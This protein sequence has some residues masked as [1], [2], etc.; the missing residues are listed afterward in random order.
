MKLRHI[1]ALCA[2]IVVASALIAALGTAVSKA[3]EKTRVNDSWLAATTKIALFADPRVKGGPV[4]VEAKQGLVMLRG[5][6]DS[7]VA[8]NA[9][10]DVA[11]GLDGVKGVKND[12]MV[13]APSRRV[14]VRDDDAAITARV[15]HHIIKE[16]RLKSTD[17]DV[18]TNAGVVSLT[19]EV[20]SIVNSA[21]ASWT[22]WQVYGVK[23]VQND[24][25]LKEK[26]YGLLPVS[27]TPS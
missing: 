25:T 5:T 19:G 21:Q 10:E 13:V 6:V 2:N 26:Q 3:S 9:S 16:S 18:K 17:I 24:L 8:K 11:K 20:S 12:L 15:K 27:K 4:Y 22:A 23:A 7:H 1:I 14:A